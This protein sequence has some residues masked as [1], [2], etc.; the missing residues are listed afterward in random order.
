M[1]KAFEF[2][3]KAFKLLHKTP[4]PSGEERETAET[5]LQFLQELKPDFLYSQPGGYGIL[6]LWKR[7]N[8]PTPPVILRC[9]MDAVYNPEE[10]K[11]QHLCGHDGHMAIML[12]VAHYLLD[13]Q[14]AIPF[15]IL[16]QP[17]E[18]NGKGARAILES[19]I[20]ERLQPR[21]MIGFHNIPEHP[22]GQIL[23]KSD[24][25]S[26]LVKSYAIQIYSAPTHAS[27]PAKHSLL[28]VIFSLHAFLNKLCFE[29]NTSFFKYTPIY[30]EMGSLHYGVSPSGAGFHFTVRGS[31]EDIFNEK[32]NDFFN[33]I[34]TFMQDVGF[35]FKCKETEYFPPIKNDKLLTEKLIELSTRLNYPLIELE[36]PFPWGEDMGYFSQIFPVCFFGI[37]SGTGKNLHT[38]DYYF[39]DHLIEK[40]IIL[41]LE[42]L[43]SI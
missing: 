37:G 25:F 36:K 24:L 40:G 3:L 28:D 20:L 19:G 5:L 16:F 21:C 13:H 34:N 4:E 32:I 43:K 14:V 11:Y 33:F 2:A 42:L 6:T 17:S 10:K 30:I 38:R 12:G 7:E 15:G 22:F 29:N 35:S 39:P 23:I 1:E 31:S 41:V 8:N 27:M 9:E 26:S 18:E